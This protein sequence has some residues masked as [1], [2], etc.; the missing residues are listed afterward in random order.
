M[1]LHRQLGTWDHWNPFEEV[2]FLAFSAL[3]VLCQSVSERH[4]ACL[5]GGMEGAGMVLA[6]AGRGTVRSLNQPLQRGK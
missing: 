3:G 1:V 6:A 5:E 4:C 2:H